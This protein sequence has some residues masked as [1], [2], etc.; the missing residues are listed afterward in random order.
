VTAARD[1]AGH[2]DRRFAGQHEADEQCGFAEDEQ[3]DEPI[4]ERT[5]ETL[6]SL[7]KKR[8]NAGGRHFTIVVDKRFVREV[9]RRMGPRS[10]VARW[11]C[12][13]TE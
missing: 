1:D 10:P 9:G 4:D 7:Q 12:V 3:G 13:V 2:D 5:R 6:N 8:K 11:R